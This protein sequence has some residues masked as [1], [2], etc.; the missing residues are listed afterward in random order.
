M[1]F[2][3]YYI[4]LGVKNTATADEIRQAYRMLAKKYHPDKNPD[5]KAAEDFFKEVQQAYMVLS[6]PEKRR[7]F[8][9]KFSY[10]HAQTQY[11][12]PKQ[13]A[14]TQ[15]TYTQ[16]TGN[17]YQYAQQQAQNRQSR[18]NAQQQRTAK[19]PD[20]S[21]NKYIFISV[22]V[23]MILLYFII[24]YSSHP[25]HTT[26]KQYTAAA[27]TQTLYPPTDA[28]LEDAAQIS[29]NSNVYS[30]HFGEETFDNK[31]R[32]QLTVYNS[33]V[34]E[35]V[36]CVV[37]QKSGRV[38]RSRYIASGSEMEFHYLPDGAY[39][40][41][42]YFGKDWNRNKQ[43]ADTTIHG[44]FRQ[45]LGF[46]KLNGGRQAMQMQQKRSGN[47][48]RSSSYEVRLDPTDKAQQTID[49]ATF[50]KTGMN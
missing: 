48:M 7:S 24:S 16:Y 17:A 21:E 41:N 35:A 40:L 14:K 20:K 44:G 23:A 30:E 15:S 27:D 13:Q 43:Y 31:S 25:K 32:N 11:Q 10:A 33:D 34:T 38:I 5:N 12:Q 22:G 2:T 4:V 37:D 28:A 9:L 46:V 3:N 29:D 49:A 26:V 45:S 1:A 36:V 50:F 6:N 42:V 18:P 19:K 39:F 47:S 8:D